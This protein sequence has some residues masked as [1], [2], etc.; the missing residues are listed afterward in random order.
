MSY[1]IDEIMPKLQV[2]FREVFDEPN[3]IIKPE[4]TANDVAQWDS[5]THIA[6]INSVEQTFG[7]VIPFQMLMEMESV[8]DLVQ[9]ISQL[10]QS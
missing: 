10:L 2:I 8:G 5:L 3:L 1:N 4:L 7:I 6:M 9:G